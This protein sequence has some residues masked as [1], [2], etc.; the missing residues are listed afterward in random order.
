MIRLMQCQNSMDPY[1]S[2]Q[3]ELEECFPTSPTIG[4]EAPHPVRQSQIQRSSSII[5]KLTEQ[6]KQVRRR[7]SLLG[8]HFGLAGSKDSG[9]DGLPGNQVAKGDKITDVKMGSEGHA[10][11]TGLPYNTRWVQLVRF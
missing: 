3:S 6:I 7:Q 5:A 2:W 9:R 8:W 4:N 10:G 11:E 1:C